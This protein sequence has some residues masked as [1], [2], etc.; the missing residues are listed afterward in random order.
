LGC[1]LLKE[2]CLNLEK[3]LKRDDLLDLDGLDLFSELNILKEIIGLKNDKPIDILNYI[4]RINS[5]PN[6]YITYKIMLTIPISI[7]SAERSFYKT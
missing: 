4:K 3:Y 5:F 7:A 2:K 1:V 6:A